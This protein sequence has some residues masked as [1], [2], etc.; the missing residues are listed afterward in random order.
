LPI[1]DDADCDHP[2][3]PALVVARTCNDSDRPNDLAFL[4]TTLSR[5]PRNVEAA[6]P[7]LNWLSNVAMAAMINLVSNNPG[8]VSVQS[9]DQLGSI[10]AHSESLGSESQSR[11]TDSS[12][13]ENPVSDDLVM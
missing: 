1:F 11:S 3:P 6:I 2:A 13:D 5:E 10:T 8:L 7:V 9:V 4:T 12:Y